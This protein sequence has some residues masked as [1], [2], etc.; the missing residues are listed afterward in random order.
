VRKTRSSELIV[1]IG[2]ARR[3]QLARVYVARTTRFTNGKRRETKASE[4][5]GDCSEKHME[6]TRHV[7][8]KA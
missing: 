1:K 3:R 4:W 7:R 5:C 2:R 8:R 6:S